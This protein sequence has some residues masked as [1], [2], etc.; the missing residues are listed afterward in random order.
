MKEEL[1]TRFAGL[2]AGLLQD[3]PAYVY[4][5]AWLQGNSDTL[6]DRIRAVLRLLMEERARGGG[7]DVLAGQW[8][9]GEVA[10]DEE[11]EGEEESAE[12][13]GWVDVGGLFDLD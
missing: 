2:G 7:S 12:G 10:E 13:P 3:N 9:C 5:A 4:A 1:A 11:E 6:A 8:L